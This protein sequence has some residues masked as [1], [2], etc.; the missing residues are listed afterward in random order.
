MAGLRPKPELL[1]QILL[2]GAGA[3]FNAFAF[4]V[5]LC[6]SGFMFW[7]ACKQ[8]GTLRMMGWAVSILVILP[9][10]IPN[11][12]MISWCSGD[13]WSYCREWQAQGERIT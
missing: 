9:S 13:L 7:F 5:I 12:I 11:C 6:L 3:M 2:C 1:T 8:D 10:T 4:V